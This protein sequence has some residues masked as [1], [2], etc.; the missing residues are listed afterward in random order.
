MTATQQPTS[1][2]SCTPGGVIARGRTR[3]EWLFLVLAVTMLA[4]AV[5]AWVTGRIVPALL[6]LAVVVIIALARRMSR[7][8]QPRAVELGPGSLT[9]ETEGHRIDVPIEGAKVRR[10]EA[11]EIRHLE[12]LA[13]VGGIVAGAGGFDSHLLGEFDLY[14]SNLQN[15]L[16]VDAPGSRLV[17]TP[18]RPDEFIE[19]IRL[20]TGSPPATIL[21]P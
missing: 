14:A 16:F 21:S 4:A 15:S 11:S 13:S 20:L 3:M 12:R 5:A 19:S 9:I 7:E 8:L 10:L 2:F 17:L 1:R 18:D 6:A